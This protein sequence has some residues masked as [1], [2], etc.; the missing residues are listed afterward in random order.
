VVARW[1]M[2]AVNYNAGIS[3]E[4][5]GGESNVKAVSAGYAWQVP[6]TLSPEARREQRKSPGE[7]RNSRLF[8]PFR[9]A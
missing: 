1:G 5:N 3:L 8:K 2:K 6:Q 4:K 9:A 7:K